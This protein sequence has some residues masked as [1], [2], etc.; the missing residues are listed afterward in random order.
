MKTPK[1]TLPVLLFVLAGLLYTGCDGTSNAYIY[2]PP[3][4]SVLTLDNDKSVTS[5]NLVIEVKIPV[6][7]V[8]IAAISLSG[9]KAYAKKLPIPIDKIE[10]IRI[11]PIS[12]F[13]NQYKALDDISPLCQ[14]AYDR[15]LTDTLSKQELIKVIN[16]IHIRGTISFYIYLKQAPVDTKQQQ[17]IIELIT[18]KNARTADT[19]ETFTLIP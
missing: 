3:N 18:D 6:R 14:F 11:R 13:N 2:L 10:D 12:S 19:T 1:A 15:D 7:E 16:D 8:D 9:N 17:F 4:V 5:E